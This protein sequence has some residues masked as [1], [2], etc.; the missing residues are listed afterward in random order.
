MAKTKTPEVEFGKRVKTAREAMG[1][2]QTKLATAMTERGHK[3]HMSTVSQLESG[4][5]SI[6]LNEAV[7]LGDLLGV[8]IP[9]QSAQG[10]LTPDGLAQTV[11]TIA[12]TLFRAG[13][14]LGDAT[15]EVEEIIAGVF[16]D[17]DEE[18]WAMRAAKAGIDDSAQERAMTARGLFSCFRVVDIAVVTPLSVLC[19]ELLLGKPLNLET[20]K[21]QAEV[22]N[23]LLD[24]IKNPVTE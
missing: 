21:R 1:W 18:Q 19:S 22:T 23:K 2:S 16:G 9:G 14:G 3:M 15:Q 11:T 8:A 13:A 6:R 20:Y 5:R 12:N 17:D 4:S 10:Q 24:L 7:A